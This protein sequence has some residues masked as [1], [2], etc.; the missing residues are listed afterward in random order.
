MLLLCKKV[1]DIEMVKKRAFAMAK[2]NCIKVTEFFASTLCPDLR[3]RSE[4]T[5]SFL[6]LEISKLVN[7]AYNWFKLNISLD[8]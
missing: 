5:K 7:L 2:I 6:K 1:R 3:M 4:K 8:N